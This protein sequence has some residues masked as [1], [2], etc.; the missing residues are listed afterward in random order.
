MTATVN[1]PFTAPVLLFSNQDM[2]ATVAS[3]VVNKGRDSKVGAQFVWTGTPTGTFS[4]WVSQ[5]GPAGPFTQLTLT[6]VTNPAGSAGSWYLDLTTFATWY[7]V[8][9][10][11]SSGDGTLNVAVGD[12]R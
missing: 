4:V 10:T 2:T 7:Y 11:A 3:P 6:S 12:A 8:Q 5:F 1:N 9:Y